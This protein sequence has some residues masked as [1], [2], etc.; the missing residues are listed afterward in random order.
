LKI[1]TINNI[2]IGDK[3]E[4][5]ETDDTWTNL[6]KGA[7]G[8]IYKIEKDQDLIWVNWETGEKLALIFGVDK[9][10]VIPKKS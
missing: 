3:I 9:F 6:K 5:I 2:K 1:L 4:L 10:K 7:K 8:T